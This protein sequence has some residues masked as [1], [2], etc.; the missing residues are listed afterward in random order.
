MAG[1][2]ELLVRIRGDSGDLE[3]A[4]DKAR[5]RTEEISAKLRDVGRKL[6]VG[7]TLPIVAMGGAAFKAASDLTESMGKTDIAF[8]TS[9][10]SVQSWAKNMDSAFGLTRRQALDAAAGLGLLFGNMGI[11]DKASADMSKKLTERAADMGSLFNAPAADVA[12][13]I[14]SAFV[15][16]SE[17]IRKFGVILNEEKVKAEAY[18]SGIATMG[19]P[20]T[21]AQKI[22][23]RY[24]IIMKESAQA[25]G[26]AGR[27]SDT[28]AGQMRS[29]KA[30]FGRASE[31]MGTKLLPI[32]QK[33]LGFLG[34][35]V[36]KFSGLS[37]E[38]QNFILGAAGIA[39]ALGPVISVMGNMQKAIGGISKAMTFLS[40]NPIILIIAAVILLAVLV[41]KNW[42][43]IK[44]VT[45]KVWG[46]IRDFLT[47][48]WDTIK[49]VAK[50][51]FNWILDHV[52]NPL[53]R[54]YNKVAKVADKIPGLNVPQL[55]EISKMQ[56]GGIV[57]KPTL[58]LIGEA[59]PEAVVPLSGGRGA[60][61]GG[62]NVTVN[63]SGSVVGANGMNELADIIHAKFLA[64]QRRNVSLGFT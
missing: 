39:A 20:L 8:G 7:V 9:G 63:V 21:E 36:D 29:L 35:L 49:S 19:A 3:S 32:G 27:T 38:T 28:A 2:A 45:L 22:Q 26:D 61:G 42:D 34:G 33:V 47:G 56:H 4:L 43:T 51:A 10:Q 17:P 48:V 6:T 40:A 44:E 30:E 31:E 14:Q 59:G 37:P 62:V 11:G 16:E 5:S 54:A 60:I 18:A 46:K 25:H 41:I 13:A 23:A 64:I 57:T 50:G 15:G 55:P 12:A 53:I 52:I 58:A 24:N 1:V